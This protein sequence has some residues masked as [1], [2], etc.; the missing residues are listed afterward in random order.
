MERGMW[1]AHMI[2]WRNR[3]MRDSEKNAFLRQKAY[4]IAFCLV[5]MVS[6]YLL[7]DIWW[8]LETVPVM[9]SGL[10]LISTERRYL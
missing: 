6:Q 2:V 7:N 9:V 1:I 3:Q 8:A 5:S 10:Y 4:G